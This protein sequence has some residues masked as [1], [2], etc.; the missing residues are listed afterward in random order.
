MADSTSRWAEALR[1]I[2][3]RLAEMP[4]DAGYPAY[5]GARLASFYE[6]SG[7]VTCLGN[8]PREGSVSIVGAVSPPGGDFTDPEYGFLQQKFKEILQKEDDLQEIVQLVGKDSLS[9]DQKC[10]LEVAKVIREDF[11]QQNGFVDYDFMCPL[12]KTIGMMRVIVTYHESAQK[13]MAETSG[14]NKIT[15]NMIYSD[16][17]VLHTKVTEMKFVLPRQP[18][19]VF[20]KTYGDLNQEL[21]D[22]FR[23]MSVKE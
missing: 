16:L 23:T 21:L 8:P 11:L 3:G 19:E 20:V 13:C 10:T 17:K 15:W 9:E 7:R 4:A 2:S 5:L 12:P 22:A 14:D 18:D 1:E 6:R